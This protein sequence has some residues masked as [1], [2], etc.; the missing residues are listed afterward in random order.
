M[1][2]ARKNSAISSRGTLNQRVPTAL[3]AR[4]AT[5]SVRAARRPAKR[6][7]PAAASTVTTAPTAIGIQPAW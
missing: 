3:S 6:V 7:A 5:G 2:L 1:P 4:A